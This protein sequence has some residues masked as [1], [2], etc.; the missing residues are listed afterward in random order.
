MWMFILGGFFL[1]GYCRF[2]VPFSM[3]I[4]MSEQIGDA[5][6]LSLLGIHRWRYVC[7][8]PRS[9]SLAVLLNMCARVRLIMLNWAGWSHGAHW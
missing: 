2:G 6:P 3:L 4:M 8:V 1:L 9:P 5:Q 7:V